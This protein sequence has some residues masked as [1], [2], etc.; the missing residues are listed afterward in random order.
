IDLGRRGAVRLILL[1]L[2]ER[3]LAA[4]GATLDAPALLALGWPGERV[5]ADAGGTR[6]RV[7]VS[8]LRRLGLAGV[9]LTR[10]DGYLLDPRV[11]IALE[12]ER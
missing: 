8:T 5:L 7:A 1:G 9:L 4:P 10:E 12:P 11:P 2:V 6:V 3:H